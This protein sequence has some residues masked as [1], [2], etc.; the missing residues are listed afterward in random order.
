MAHALQ[1]LHPLPCGLFSIRFRKLSVY[2]Q[3]VAIEP[4]Q[5]QTPRPK[6]FFATL[7]P[8]STSASERRSGASLPAAPRGPAGNSAGMAVL[9]GPAK[10]NLALNPQEDSLFQKEVTQVQQRV[11]KVSGRAGAPARRSWR[12]RMGSRPLTGLEAAVQVRRLGQAGNQC[13]V[14]L[15]R[16]PG[17]SWRQRGSTCRSVTRP[18]VRIS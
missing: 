18:D 12:G 2:G 4:A 16:P 6:Q 1:A 15:F 10:P 7:P 9:D 14:W 8:A 17:L 11:K 5:Y 13:G 3:Q